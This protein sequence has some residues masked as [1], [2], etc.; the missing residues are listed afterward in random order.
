[1]IR[2][3]VWLHAAVL[4]IATSISLAAPAGEI[5]DAIAKRDAAAAKSIIA[6]D[7]S[8][9]SQRDSQNFLPL[10]LAA[11]GGDLEICRALIAAGADVN[12]STQPG[13]TGSAADMAAAAQGKKVSELPPAAQATILN[14]AGLSGGFT[15]LHLA[16]N[17][18]QLAICQYLLSAGA[19]PEA[20]DPMK[21]TALHTAIV[22]G[23]ADIAFLLIKSGADVNALENHGQSPV[24][25]AAEERQ[26]DVVD[27][28]LKAKATPCIKDSYNVTPLMAA[29]AGD[30]GQEGEEA[31]PREETLKICRM[32]VSRGC[33]VN[34][35]ER[36]EGGTAL[37]SAAVCN[38]PEIGRLLLENGADP[39][40]LWRGQY[41]ALDI[42]TL[43]AQPPESD[44]E[45]EIRATK[46]DAREFVKL[47]QKAGG[48]NKTPY[49]PF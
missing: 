49:S 27:A 3:R 33:D 18:G 47:L 13:A 35:A 1:M 24:Y 48:K 21:K 12:A 7:P 39:N 15:A 19:N 37:I 8:C 40:A 4:L 16:A 36:Y 43:S 10:H 44:D 17:E 9:I 31:Y 32:L 34:A 6:R 29:I 20:R 2:S 14:A 23:H 11:M 45:P 5:H 25:L 22:M 30:G 42:V 28:L 41:T 26:S 46:K 38:Q